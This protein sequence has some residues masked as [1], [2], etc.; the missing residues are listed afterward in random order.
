M[1]SYGI[2]Y[3]IIGIVGFSNVYIQNN[4]VDNTEALYGGVF[5]F[6]SVSNIYMENNSISNSFSRSEG[7]SLYFSKI[8]SISIVKS[9]FYNTSSKSDAGCIYLRDI[10]TFF[11]NDITIEKSEAKIRGGT[12]Y[13]IKTNNAIIEKI[14]V[15]SSSAE[16]GGVFY[17]DEQTNLN[18][19]DNYFDTGRSDIAGGLAYIYGD[20]MTIYFFNNIF[21]KFNSNQDGA[22]IYSSNIKNLT[23]S[24]CLIK[25]SYVKNS[26]LGIIYLEGY[27]N[28]IDVGN[29][30]VYTFENNL[31]LNNS[32]YFGAIIYYSSNSLLNISNLTSKLSTGSLLS[33]ES[34]LTGKIYMSHVEILFTNYKNDISADNSLIILLKCSLFIKW[35]NI[36]F[37][38]GRSHLF[39]AVNSVFLEIDSSFFIDYFIIKNENSSTAVGSS[40]KLFNIYKSELSSNKN[41]MSYS[42]ANASNMNY[43]CSFFEIRESVFNSYYDYFSNLSSKEVMFFMTTD[44][45]NITIWF[46]SLFELNPQ[47][48]IFLLKESSLFFYDSTLDIK[49]DEL[50]FNFMIF[51]GMG[52]QVKLKIEKCQFNIYNSDLIYIRNAHL[53]NFSEIAFNA[54]KNDSNFKRGI[55]IIN[56]FLI[57]MNEVSFQNFFHESGSCISV[58][59]EKSYFSNIHISKS[60]FNNNTAYAASAILIAGNI[61]LNI[62]NAF[63]LNN[64]AI[65]KNNDLT[66]NFPNSGKGGCILIDCEY[67]QNCSASLN[68]SSFKNNYADSLGPTIISKSS[69]KIY[70]EKVSFDGNSD[71]LSFST[72]YLSFPMLFYVLNDNL[73]DTLF[74]KYFENIKDNLNRTNTLI[75]TYELNTR[76]TIASGQPFN[77]SLLLTDVSNQQIITDNSIRSTLNCKESFGVNTSKMIIDKGSA[78]SQSGIIQFEFVSLIYFPNSTLNCKIEF[79]YSD[80]IFF[81][82]SNPEKKILNRFVQVPLDLYIR[83]CIPGELYQNDES[84]FKCK[85][86]TYALHEAIQKDLSKK[87]LACPSHAYCD[88]GNNLSP[89]HGYW[90]I[91]NKSSLIQKCPTEE[92]CL[93]VGENIE[94]IKYYGLIKKL[95]EE[96]KTQGVCKDGYWG[97]L[98]YYCRKGTARFKQRAPCEDCEKLAI[99]YIKMILALIFMMVYI[100]IQ[101]KIFS[102][103]EQKEPHLAILSK[104]L[105]SHF[106]TM[107]MMDL[108][109]LGWTYDFS[110]Y[111]SIKDYLSF[112]SEDFF[113]IDCIIKEWGGDLL[114]NKIIFTIM[115]PLILS[116]LMFIFWTTGFFYIMMLKK[117]AFSDK[118][119]NFLVEKMRITVLIFIFILYPEILKKGFSLLNCTIIDEITNFKVLA[120][121]PNMECWSSQHVFWVL[122][123]SLP[124]ILFWGILAP[125]LILMILMLY[126][127]SIFQA[128]H[129]NELKHYKTA[130]ENDPNKKGTVSKKVV[131]NIQKE[132]AEKVF[133]YGIPPP[134]HEI[135]YTKKHLAF[136]ESQEI[137]ILDA[138]TLDLISNQISSNRKFKLLLPSTNK[139]A[140]RRKAEE[141]VCQDSD[142]LVK[143][144]DELIDFLGNDGINNNCISEKDLIENKVFIQEKYELIYDYEKKMAAKKISPHSAEKMEVANTTQVI[145]RNLGFIFRGYQKDRY[146]WEIVMFSRKFF[147]IFI[148]NRI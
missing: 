14:K 60:F 79:Y 20:E 133:V 18:A 127:K 9:K 121:S 83:T 103:V 53:V 146:Y 120:Q 52:A 56:T 113:V 63:F 2:K 74:K 66:S 22:I 140:S 98:C 82:S 118:I 123:V 38:F 36:T 110:F 64:K 131:I 44:K 25:D 148:G 105:L 84:C 128:I 50:D 116:A 45:S 122:T 135:A 46:T 144:P 132:L 43:E 81:K 62:S 13:L 21:S 87:C 102:N 69:S 12:F 1:N 8:D 89:L 47:A 91:N 73:T 119:Y 65:F 90:R 28:V 101:A 55:Q 104:L 134:K 85:F 107:S 67:F 130:F 70:L 51:D 6:I 58:I 142:F 5:A 57:I 80:E 4:I 23:L 94:A 88:G 93:G 136:I 97:N 42:N 61:F 137:K 54:E 141:I 143:K 147:F 124:G 16:K 78:T 139:I 117:S 109:E 34:D 75:S 15:L 100:S 30:K 126:H 86:G 11:L 19:Y 41:L 115:L 24:N 27:S 3:G 29:E 59:A 76:M 40:N 129:R 68:I 32:A 106:Q 33:L 112:L 31:F 125:F 71:G 7:G 26:G 114:V 35:A 111:F 138:E 37:N 145:V 95:T 39:E 77:F 99:I 48:G 17:I 92:G 49:S 10:E 72:K 96:Q 108:I